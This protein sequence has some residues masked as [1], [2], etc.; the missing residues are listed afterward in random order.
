[1]DCPI[2]LQTLEESDQVQKCTQCVATYHV[3]CFVKAQCAVC[4]KVFD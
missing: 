1:M 2:C 4:R 3:A